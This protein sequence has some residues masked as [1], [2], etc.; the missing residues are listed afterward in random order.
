MTFRAC[1]L[2]QCRGTLVISY[3]QMTQNAEAA[4]KIIHRFLTQMLFTFVEITLYCSQRD[5][6]FLFLLTKRIYISSSACPSTH[7]LLIYHSTTNPYNR[8]RVNTTFTPGRTQLVPSFLIITHPLGKP[9]PKARQRPQPQ[10]QP[11]AQ[12]S[13]DSGHSANFL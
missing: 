7:R 6:P 4:T 12:K 9:E 13:Q 8:H 3:E 1:T 10:A 2:P 11:H 5:L